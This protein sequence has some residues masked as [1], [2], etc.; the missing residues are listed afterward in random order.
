MRGET[1]AGIAHIHLADRTTTMRMSKPRVRQH[2]KSHTHICSEQRPLSKIT[3]TIHP[4]I[5]QT[6]A[7]I[8][9][10]LLKSTRTSYRS[11]YM[12]TTAENCNICCSHIKLQ[13]QAGWCMHYLCDMWNK[14]HCKHRRFRPEEH[15]ISVSLIVFIVSEVQSGR[16]EFTWKS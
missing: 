7:E 16:L 12:K 15:M 13:V 6:H 10:W 4:L 9:W 3:L 1:G 5:S 8:N 14:L 11:N 2:T